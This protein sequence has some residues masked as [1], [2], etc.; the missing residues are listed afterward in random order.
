[1]KTKTLTKG[2]KPYKGRYYREHNGTYVSVTSVIHPE[3]LDFPPELL[4]QYASRGTMIHD[5]VEHFL[6]HGSWSQSDTIHRKEDIDNVKN[7]S[8][9]LKM[10]DC[11]PEGFLKEYGDRIEAKYVEKKLFNTTH[12]YAGRADII[13][14][15]DGEWSIMDV[16]TAG[17]YTPDKLIDY[18]KQQAAYANCVIPPLKKMVIL[19]INPT[20][21]TGYDAPLIETDVEHYFNLFLKDLKHL[22][23]TYLISSI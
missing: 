17:N 11:N 14:R 16:K 13:G 7:G 21:P 8:L 15:F 4:K 9:K 6:T 5:K 20:T 3:G 18:W 23:D 12:K 10:E 2:K 19:P 1:M 22:H